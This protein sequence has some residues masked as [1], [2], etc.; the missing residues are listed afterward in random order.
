MF[1][2]LYTFPRV[3][4][5]R[6]G[7]TFRCTHTLSVQFIFMKF[8]YEAEVAFVIVHCSVHV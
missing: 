5:H 6:I 1:F 7:R 8:K 3:F 4:V 2:Y